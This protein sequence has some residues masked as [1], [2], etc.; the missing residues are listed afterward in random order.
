MKAADGTEADIPVAEVVRAYPANQLGL[1]SSLAIY[2]SRWWEYLWDDPRE[3]NAEGGV[4]PAI[5]GTVVMTMIMT[6]FTAMPLTMWCLTST[7]QFSS[8]K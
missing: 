7:I 2:V 5:F 1:G 4:W 3:A 6:R 8:G